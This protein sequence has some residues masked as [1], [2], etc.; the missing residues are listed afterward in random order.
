MFGCIDET[1]LSL[2]AD[3]R[4]IDGDECETIEG[5]FQ[6]ALRLIQDQDVNEVSI[7]PIKFYGENGDGYWGEIVGEPGI[8]LDATDVYWLDE[9]E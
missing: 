1:S 6:E 3:P 7:R 5:A 4:G 8:R 9:E 2:S